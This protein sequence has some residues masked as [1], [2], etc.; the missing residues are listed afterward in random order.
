MKVLA[1]P[2]PC[3]RY[4][5]GLAG[6]EGCVALSLCQHYAESDVLIFHMFVIYFIFI[7]TFMEAFF[8]DLVF[9]ND[10]P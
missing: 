7:D 6:R 4:G 9:M 10:T 5:A 2:P 3:L 8:N 1:L